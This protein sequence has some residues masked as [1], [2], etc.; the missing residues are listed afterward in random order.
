[1]RGSSGNNRI[2]QIIVMPSTSFFVSPVIVA[3]HFKGSLVQS[4][5]TCQQA[6]IR[7][8]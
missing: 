4:D 1:M 5:L 8:A 3:Q 7:L 2:I 6:K